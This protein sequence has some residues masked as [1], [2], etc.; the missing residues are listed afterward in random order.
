MTSISIGSDIS[1]GYFVS[2]FDSDKD[3]NLRPLSREGMA[4]CIL[5]R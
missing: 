1:N 5:A 2:D 4:V 3:N